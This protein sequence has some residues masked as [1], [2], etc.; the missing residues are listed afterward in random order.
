MALTVILSVLIVLLAIGIFSNLVLWISAIIF[1]IIPDKY[2][3][4]PY[5]TPGITILK[6]ARG[7]N[8]GDEENFRSFF[9]LDYPEYELMFLIH[10]DAGEDPAVNLINKLIQEYP[11]VDAKLV[12][13]TE[14]KAV[15][16]KVNNYFEGISKAK[17]GI[18]CIT[19]ADCY[20]DKDYLKHDIKPLS[21]PSIG[22]VTSMQTM[23]DFHSLPTAFEGLLQ[24]YENCLLWP[25]MHN[26]NK[27]HFVYGHSIFFRK[28]EFYEFNAPKILKD[29]MLDDM[30]WGD[31][32]VDNGKKRIWLSKKISHTRYPKSTWKK[33]HNHILRWAVFDFRYAPAYVLMPI[34]QNTFL[35]IVT[36]ILAFTA[37]PE[38]TFFGISMQNAAL[39][40]SF[41]AIAVRF[42]GMFMSNLL[43]GDKKKDLKYFWLI[44]FRDIYST[45]IA[46]R[47]P[48]VNKFEHAGFTY[49][50]VKT[51]LKK[52]K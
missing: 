15:H 14:H 29:H 19:D 51:K 23:N 26:V 24:N 33:V 25:L 10:N 43:L 47:A 48:F 2:R 21:D 45:Y 32:F 9:E 8:P 6:P 11:N 41:G 50:I 44:P 4:V 3:N 35:G 5:F 1:K 16:E 20:V 27:L 17:H 37:N 22:M 39:I 46:L 49:K 18:I 36:M 7:V 40:F 34:I 31:V 52:V 30:G 28:K 42:I 12:R 13:P 38:A